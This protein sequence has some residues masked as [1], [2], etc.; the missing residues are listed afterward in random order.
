M[1]FAQIKAGVARQMPFTL[2]TDA[3]RHWSQGVDWQGADTTGARRD[4]HT[5]QSQF[6]A[7]GWCRYRLR[8]IGWHLAGEALFQAEDEF[9]VQ[10]AA[11]GLG[12]LLYPFAQR[13]GH[14]ELEL[15]KGAL[16][17]LRSP[18]RRRWFCPGRGRGGCGG[19]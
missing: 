13:G 14:A 8:L 4:Q 3:G 7:W 9:G 15:G 18:Q 6:S 2:A 1:C 19:G 12:G 17:H 5:E 16:I 11:G 10:G